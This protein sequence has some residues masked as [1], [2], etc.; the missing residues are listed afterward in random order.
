MDLAWLASWLEFI[1]FDDEF[2]YAF[3][4]LDIDELGFFD[5]ELDDDLFSWEI[6]WISEDEIKLLFI[7]YFVFEYFIELLY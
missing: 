6:S 1:D 5:E 7:I 2:Y 4:V 3:D